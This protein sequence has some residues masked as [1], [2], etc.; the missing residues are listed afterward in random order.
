MDKAK[1]IGGMV[2]TVFILCY[3][4]FM[5]ASIRHVATFF[6]NFEPNNDNLLGS[7]FLAGAFD[8][9]ALVT[10]I[11]VM[12][13][14]KSMPAWVFWVVWMFIAAIAIYSY[15]INLEYA[16]H[17]QDTTLLLQPTGATTPILDS[18]GN[19]HYVAVMQINRT[20]QYVNPFLA[21]GFTIFSLI[22]SVIAEFFGTKP[23]TAEELL[24]RKQYLEET[25]GIQEEIQ[26]L[27]AKG[28]KD[29]AIGAFG[30]EALGFVGKQADNRKARMESRRNELLNA[31]VDYLRDA[32]ELL[33]KDQEKR[34]ISALSTFLKIKQKEALP[35]LIAARS[36]MTKEEEEQQSSM[37]QDEE[38]ASINEDVI[39]TESETQDEEEQE[40][41][42]EKDES[43]HTGQIPV[44]FDVI[45][46]FTHYPEIR[47]WHSAKKLTASIDEIIKATG[48]RRSTVEE[49]IGNGQLIRSK[50]RDKIRVSSVVKWIKTMPV[51][52]RSNATK[53]RTTGELEAISV[54]D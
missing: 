19:V 4:A 11:G 35:L 26:K 12:F 43:Q 24:A 6:N 41:I 36:R 52:S 3:V 50:N 25:S 9:T 17:Y 49:A 38:V 47:S 15:I 18:H 31:T 32:R 23:P 51:R 10:T 33:D 2:K 37:T 48:K 30:K 13:F 46:V 40:L 20:L 5:V 45:K 27:E 28:K 42:E 34:A 7:Y 1:F 29:N 8:I 39:D 21:S 16:S 54:G 53:E 22:Y 14:R 44:D